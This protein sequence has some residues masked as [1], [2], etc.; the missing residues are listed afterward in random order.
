MTTRA[1][2][3]LGPHAVTVRADGGQRTYT[4]TSLLNV[5]DNISDALPAGP[6]H[7]EL[8][9]IIVRED[10][11]YQDPP[12]NIVV[13][14]VGDPIEIREGGG[15]GSFAFITWR[16]GASEIS[17]AHPNS[18]IYRIEAI[19]Y[20]W[21]SQIDYINPVDPTDN[22]LNLGDWVNRTAQQIVESSTVAAMEAK[23]GQIIR[24]PVWNVV[25]GIGQNQRFQVSGFIKV[26]VTGIDFG[27]SSK[28]I[29]G[30]FM[31]LDNECGY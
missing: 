8:L 12:T 19:I 28:I 31:G 24:L 23:I 21:Y 10:V 20:P 18:S 22:T 13:W 9:P 4:A 29:Y 30:E 6:K 11:I 26:R 15:S 3:P 14:P 16:Q 27:G 17:N 2:V 25:Q 7:C 1:G 5:T